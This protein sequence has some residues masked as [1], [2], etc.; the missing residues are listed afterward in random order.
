MLRTFRSSRQSVKGLLRCSDWWTTT[1]SVFALVRFVEVFKETVSDNPRVSV[2]D[3]LEPCIGCMANTAN[4]TLVRWVL[5]S[6]WSMKT[7]TESDWSGR[8]SH[9]KKEETML[10]LTATADLCGALTAWLNG[11]LLLSWHHSRTSISRFASR[12]DQS[13]PESWLGS[14]CP[15]P[16]CRSKFCVRDVRIIQWEKIYILF[17]ITHI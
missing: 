7:N 12:Q 11:N 1:N 8:V 5:A 9:S 16:T 6:Y 17:L 3:E 14:Q 4:I 10:V 13:N 2:S 15:C